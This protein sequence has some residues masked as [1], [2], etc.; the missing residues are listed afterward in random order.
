LFTRSVR[1]NEPAVGTPFDVTVQAVDVFGQVAFG[2]TGMV[3]FSV[4]DT[5]PAVVLPLDYTFTAGDQGRH[6]FSGAFTLITPG[7]QTLT[8]ADLADGLSIDVPITVNP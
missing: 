8:V 1:G 7:G 3:T 4:T 6:T 5:D 2:Y